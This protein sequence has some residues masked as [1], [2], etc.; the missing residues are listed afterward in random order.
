MSQEAVETDVGLANLALDLLLDILDLL[1]IL[2]AGKVVQVHPWFGQG[3]ITELA[4]Y[5][6][7]VF[8]HKLL[9]FLTTD[10]V[11]FHGNFRS[12]TLSA[13]GALEF[14]ILNSFAKRSFGMILEEGPA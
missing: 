12:Q 1:W 3:Q 11:L 10:G 8:F 4:F 6:L 13:V 2:V 14:V 7:A 9:D 5:A